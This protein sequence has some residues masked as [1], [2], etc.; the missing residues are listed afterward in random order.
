MSDQP[1]AGNL[2]PLLSAKDVARIL[3]C[4]V[5]TLQRLRSAGKIP[6]PDIRLGRMPRWK[7][8]TIKVWIANGGRT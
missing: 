7:A 6:R 5:R 4:S 3:N 2:E 1:S 8:E